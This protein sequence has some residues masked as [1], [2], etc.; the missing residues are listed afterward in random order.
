MFKVLNNKIKFFSLFPSNLSPLVHNAD[1]EIWD[2]D[3]ENNG[4]IYHT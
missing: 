1:G 3:T 2:V 4:Q